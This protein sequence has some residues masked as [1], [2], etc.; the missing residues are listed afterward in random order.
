MRKHVKGFV[1][2]MLFVLVAFVAAFWAFACLY[3]IIVGLVFR[4][5]ISL[6][7]KCVC[8]FTMWADARSLSDSKIMLIACCSFV[9]GLSM[10]YAC[11][12]IRRLQ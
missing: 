8:G 7:V 4:W 12:Y 6:M 9:L 10:L 2:G 11:R 5:L 3:T 1:N